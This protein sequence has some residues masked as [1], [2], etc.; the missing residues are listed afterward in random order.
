[1][2]DYLL[3]LVEHTHDL[4]CIDLIKIIGTDR[5]TQIVGLAE[6]MSVVVEGEFKNPHADFIGTFGMPNLNKLKILLNLPEY[7]EGAKLGLSRRSGGEPDGINFENAVGDFKNNY[8][9][10]AEAIVSE[11]LKMPKNRTFRLALKMA[12]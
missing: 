10:M 1:M 6:D 8:R 4:G 9:F 2:R 3:D 7:R 11:K 5:S 12:I